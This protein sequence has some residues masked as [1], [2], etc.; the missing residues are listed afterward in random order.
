MSLKKLTNKII[1]LTLMASLSSLLVSQTK[2]SHPSHP[3][4]YIGSG[5]SPSNGDD[6]CRQA[7]AK[8][9]GYRTN[10]NIQWGQRSTGNIIIYAHDGVVING[11]SYI[12]YRQSTG[13][14]IAKK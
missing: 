11:A 3:F 2:I 14:C 1:A 8:I 6:L 5:Y 7:Y 12:G 4:Q 10:S 9:G 13:E